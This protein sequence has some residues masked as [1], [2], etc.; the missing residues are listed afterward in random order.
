MRCH[1]RLT[2]MGLPFS[3]ERL[4]CLSR[5][6]RSNRIHLN[7]E[8]KVSLSAYLPG[9]RAVFMRKEKCGRDNVT[10]AEKLRY[11]ALLPADIHTMRIGEEPADLFLSDEE[12]DSCITVTHPVGTS[13]QAIVAAARAE[14]IT[15]A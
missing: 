4:P 5:R 7:E 13:R 3:E 1:L 15:S 10:D 2:W 14:V 9:V 11:P 12:D 6:P 8:R